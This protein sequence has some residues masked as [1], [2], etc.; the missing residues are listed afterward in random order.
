MARA[1]EHAGVVQPWPPVRCVHPGD[2]V[3]VDGCPGDLR[4]AEAS[5][6]SSWAMR[7][8]VLGFL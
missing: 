1:V 6:R 5:E 3:V 4:P 7:A 2:G 8:V